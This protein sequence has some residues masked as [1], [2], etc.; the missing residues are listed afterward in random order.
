[1]SARRI[2]G[3][4]VQSILSTVKNT[5]TRTVFCHYFVSRFEILNIFRKLDSEKNPWSLDA[6]NEYSSISVPFTDPERIRPLSRIR[7]QPV[8]FALHMTIGN[9]TLF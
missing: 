2:M 4:P 5:I 3:S 9:F 6:A 7:I 8:G 1:M